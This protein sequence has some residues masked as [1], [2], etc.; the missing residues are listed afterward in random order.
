VR[1]FGGVAA[2]FIAAVS[3][4]GGVNCA[5][6]QS[7]AN[8][9]PVE[10]ALLFSGFDLWRHDGFVHGGLLWS[11]DG[12][13]REG[14]SL[15]VLFAGGNYDYLSGF[16]QITGRQVLT[17]VMPGWRFKGEHYEA[18]LFAGPDLQSNGYV[19]D[20]PGN[21]LHGITAGLRVG[22]DI[23]Y[24]PSESFMATA[25]VSAATT[26]ANFWGRTAIG[27]R[28]LDWAWV[29]PEASAFGDHN[30]QQL[31]LGIHTTA[32]RTGAFEWSAGFGEVWD[33]DGRSG[34]YGRIGLLTRR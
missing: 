17:A 22:G 28:F 1:F 32:F 13:A 30:Y 2:A 11:P 25:A 5:F 31:R 19:P 21:R 4:V 20:D 33:S 27:W 14:F 23:W 9:G 12:L 26:G 6:A 10:R 24:Q 8:G 18:M 7:E 29:G 16:N 15:K 3:I 34:V